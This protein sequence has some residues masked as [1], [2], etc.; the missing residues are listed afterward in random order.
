MSK[1][2]K[3]SRLIAEVDLDAIRHNI[4]EVKRLIN[5]GTSVMAIIKADGYGHGAIP[6]ADALMARVDAFGVATVSEAANLRNA[7]VNKM[8]LILGYTPPEFYEDIVEYDISQTVFTYDMALE[9]NEEAKR[10][11][12]KAKVHIKVDTGMSR[13]GMEP[14]SE[15]ADMVKNIAQLS[16]I[17]IEGVFTHF[18][19]ADE[20]DLTSAKKQYEKFDAFVKMLKER[21][22]A[23]AYI[24]CSNSAGI[25]E[26]PQAHFNMVR[27]GIIT[28][29]MYPSDEV[30]KSL[31]SIR[32]ALA[33]RSNVVYVKT[34]P[35]GREISYGG[36]FV[37]KK[38]T[39]VATIP[40]GYADGYPRALSGKGYVLI[41]G[42][43][44]PILGRVCMDQMMVD[45]TDIEDVKVGDAVT[46]IGA[47]SGVS[48][49]VE[50]IAA[51]CGTINY[52]IVCNLS[53]RVP[54]LYYSGGQIIGS[55]D[56]TRDETG[57]VVY[58]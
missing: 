38:E 46:L 19:R 28:Y 34:L 20:K 33:V 37:T 41:K 45:V 29:G 30:D 50:E 55:M 58:L 54:R 16:N 21:G 9:L 5:P 47:N 22:I 15:N 11:G 39:V 36:T 40:V 31:L 25:M 4:D 3:Y 23:P 49:T 51:M 18:A 8:I 35:A 53:K 57:A 14:T 24:H 27:S 2:R 48:I 32:P 26:L 52:E 12:K 43:K 56:Y 6:V 44:A 1:K 17:E 7:G 42:K 10:A 13:I